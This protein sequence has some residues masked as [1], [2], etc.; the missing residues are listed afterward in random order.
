MRVILKPGV[1]LR[2]L[3]PETAFLIERIKEC[4]ESVMRSSNSLEPSSSLRITS[5][6]EGIHGPN[7]LHYV[8]FAVDSGLPRFYPRHNQGPVIAEGAI[9]QIIKLGREALGAEFDIVREATHIHWEY[10]PEGRA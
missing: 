1:S 2:G 7:S 10:Q 6:T 4:Y 8:G 9:E 5:V 3:R